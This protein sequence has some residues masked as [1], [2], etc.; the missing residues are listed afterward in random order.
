MINNV[1]YRVETLNGWD[2]QNPQKAYLSKSIS[3][4]PIDCTKEQFYWSTISEQK[5]RNLNNISRLLVNTSLIEV[6]SW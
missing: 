4:M 6:R 1:T 3:L 5:L 2:F